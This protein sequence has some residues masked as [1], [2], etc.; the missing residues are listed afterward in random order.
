M[1][2]R[3]QRGQGDNEFSFRY[4]EFEVLVLDNYTDYMCNYFAFNVIGS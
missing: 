2:S 1:V 4:V 3:R